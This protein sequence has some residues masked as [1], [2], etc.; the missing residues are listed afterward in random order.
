MT[1]LAPSYHPAIV[2]RRETPAHG[3]GL[4]LQLSTEGPPRW[5]AD[6]EAA[7]SFASIREAARAAARL[8]ATLGAYGLPR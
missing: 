8:P 7:T 2:S 1:E 5:T 3:Q 4:Y 6:P